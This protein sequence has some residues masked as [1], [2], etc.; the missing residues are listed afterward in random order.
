MDNADYTIYEKTANKS[1]I[2]QKKGVYMKI[3]YSDFKK[4]FADGRL[5]E[6]QRFR[7]K[8]PETYSRFYADYQKEQGKN[9]AARKCRK[10]C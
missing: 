9:S 2:Q 1:D 3:G 4:M 8:F 6:I 5:M 7:M 10:K